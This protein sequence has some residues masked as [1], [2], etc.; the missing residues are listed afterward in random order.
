MMDILFENFD[1]IEFAKSFNTDNFNQF[2]ALLSDLDISDIDI[3]AASKA[4]NK[5]LENI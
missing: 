5:F 1:N 3:S 2:I 4:G